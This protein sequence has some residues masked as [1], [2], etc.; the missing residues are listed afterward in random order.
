[1]LFYCE[2]LLPPPVSFLCLSQSDHRS[3]VSFSTVLACSKRVH[4]YIDVGSNSAS[5]NNVKLPVKKHSS[6]N[7]NVLKNRGGEHLV[8]YIF[9][10]SKIGCTPI[11]C[12]CH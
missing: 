5:R 2:V 6:T 1:M 4:F 9:L 7:L 8:K 11:I 10:S 3:L 12:I